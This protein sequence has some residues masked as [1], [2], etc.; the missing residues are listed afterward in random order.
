MFVVLALA[1]AAVAEPEAAA[2]AQCFGAQCF[3]AAPL[4]TTYNH[5][6]YPTTYNHVAAPLTTTYNR[7]FTH[8]PT[9][10]ALSASPLLRH[11]IA[12]REAEAEADPAL[13]YNTYAPYTSTYAATAYPY[14]HVATPF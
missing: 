4:T 8:F 13:L 11:F 9:H 6:A 3:G 14:S 5:V 10:S 1:A 7:A 12:K 2:D